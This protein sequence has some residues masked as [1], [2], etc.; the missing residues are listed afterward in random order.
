MKYRQQGF[1]LLALGLLGLSLVSTAQS[2]LEE[3]WEKNANRRQPP[4]QVMDMVGIKPGMI[5]GEVGAGRGRYT[6][7]LS[8]RVGDQGRIYAN[9]IDRGALEYLKE[10]CRRNGLANV[11]TV[12][13]KP[14]DPLFPRT[15]LDMIFMVWTYHMM[16]KPVEMLRSFIPYLRPG[17]LVVMVEPV[18][19]ETEEEIKDA[20]ARLGRKPSDINA[21]SEDSVRRDAAAA[22]FDLVRTDSSLTKDNVFIFSR[23]GGRDDR[24]HA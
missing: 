18:P 17:A 1:G 9:D 2:G 16:S 23:R 11:E 22:G 19:E 20:T 7:H 24:S 5:I 8:R 13:G 12:L 4:D 15:G 14:D 10:R 6:V 3:T 21:V